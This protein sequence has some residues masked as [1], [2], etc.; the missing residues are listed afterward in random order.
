MSNSKANGFSVNSILFNVR[1]VVFDL[2]LFVGLIN[3]YL[4]SWYQIIPPA[5]ETLSYK[6]LLVTSGFLHAHIVGKLAFPKVIWDSNEQ[7][8]LKALR[9]LLYAVFVYCYSFGA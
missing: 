8:M 4:N 5:L 3:L 6:A 7:N 2:V 1:R 9:I